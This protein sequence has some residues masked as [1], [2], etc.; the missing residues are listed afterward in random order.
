MLAC[1]KATGQ[2]FQIL[3][4]ILS[5]I[6]DRTARNAKL[7]CEVSA[8]SLL[9]AL[10]RSSVVLIN[11][12]VVLILY[13][14]QYPKKQTRTEVPWKCTPLN[15]LRPISEW[16]HCL[17]SLVSW[18]VSLVALNQAN[19]VLYWTVSLTAGCRVQSLSKSLNVR[20]SSILA[21]RCGLAVSLVI[22]FNTDCPGQRLLLLILRLVPC[23]TGTEVLRKYVTD[24]RT[25]NW[26]PVD[27]RTT[28]S[29][30][31]VDHVLDRK[32]KL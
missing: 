9:S 23:N 1:H 5:L 28:S 26:S 14:F 31:F 21:V 19:F 12:F 6:P 17:S 15:S 11:W 32:R 8:G 25:G 13:N 4:G 27:R 24:D 3:K 22:L 29:P 10:V 30:V 2:L 7:P 20:L 16:S 18:K